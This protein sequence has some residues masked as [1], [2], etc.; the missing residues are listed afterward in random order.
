M[1]HR[2]RPL[3]LRLHSALSAL[4]FLEES[5]RVLFSHTGSADLGRIR[6]HTAQAYH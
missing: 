2:L 1:I 6:A 4:F 5:I 3:L